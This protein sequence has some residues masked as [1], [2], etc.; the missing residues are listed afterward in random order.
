MECWLIYSIIVVIIVGH[1]GNNPYTTFV[2]SLSTTNSV[3]ILIGNKEPSLLGENLTNKITLVV[4]GYLKNVIQHFLSHFVFVS[5]IIQPM[6]RNCACKFNVENCPSIIL[7]GD[8]SRQQIFTNMTKPR[9]M[10]HDNLQEHG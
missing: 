3:S 5:L 6:P 8:E 2:N 1:A 9:T 4:T 10:V 7:S